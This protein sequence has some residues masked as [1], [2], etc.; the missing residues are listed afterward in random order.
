[1]RCVCGGAR[2]VAVFW[3]CRVRVCACPWLFRR[4]L[5]RHCHRSG[6]CVVTRR[7]GFV[8][9]EVVR[10][11]AVLRVG[12]AGVVVRAGAPGEGLDL[13]EGEVVPRLAVRRR[14]EGDVAVVVFVA[15]IGVD[16]VV[17]AVSRRLREDQ[18]AARST[19]RPCTTWWRPP[20]ALATCACTSCPLRTSTRPRSTRSRCSN[21]HCATQPLGHLL[22]S[23]P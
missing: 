21:S 13:R 9:D 8:D 11:V 17:V 16:V 6:S 18:P 19:R 12:R 1:M 22:L 4:S 3:V 14:V 2:W 23:R 15:V 5:S 10:G 20:R 7:R